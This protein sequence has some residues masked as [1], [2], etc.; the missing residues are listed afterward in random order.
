MKSLLEKADEIL[1][2][3]PESCLTSH[4]QK[5]PKDKYRC[6]V[7]DL[8][9]HGDIHPNPGPRRKNRN[10]V[11]NL[12]ILTL[13]VQ[14]SPT[15]WKVLEYV[16]T[17]E[18]Q[19]IAIQECWMSQLD[20]GAFQVSAAEKGCLPQW[21]PCQASIGRWNTPWQN[22]G[23]LTLV[24]KAVSRKVD[25]TYSTLVGQYLAIRIGV[26]FF[27]ISTSNR[28][29][30][31]KSFLEH[32]FDPLLQTRKIPFFCIG[33]WNLPPDENPFIEALQPLDGWVLAK[34]KQDDPEVLQP[35]RWEY[36]GVLD[37]AVTNICRSELGVQFLLGKYADPS[38]NHTKI[39][40][41]LF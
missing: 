3:E 26:F 7:P 16:T 28:K 20:C 5:C 31:P 27:A 17:A 12:R 40:I 24:S 13:T 9:Q 14:P 21:Q 22:R 25:C 39:R 18:F 6:W 10:S 35:T 41:A 19:V 23:V 38:A 29:Q 11:S 37:Y 30:K 2:N 4:G 36:K 8:Y 32:L 1:N 34:I 33:D 15:A